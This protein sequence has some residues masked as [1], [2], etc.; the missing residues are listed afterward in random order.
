MPKDHSGLVFNNFNSALT[1][2]ASYVN[3]LS[4]SEVRLIDCQVVADDCVGS[5]D[6]K[7][8]LEIC[9]V[10]KNPVEDASGKAECKALHGNC[11]AAFTL[12][13]LDIE[14]WLEDP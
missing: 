6:C 9:S 3:V 12:V 7:V 11:G 8:D 10:D 14:I 4:L 1:T 2:P 13:D 5:Q